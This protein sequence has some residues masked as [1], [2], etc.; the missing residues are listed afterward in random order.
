MTQTN[1]DWALS[2]LG[3]QPLLLW[4]EPWAEEFEVPF[5][6]TIALSFAG[7][8]KDYELGDFDAASDNLVIWASAG[9]TV[10]VYIDGALQD[11]SSAS[12][13]VPGGF[14]GSTREFLNLVFA[15]Q[16]SARLGGRKAQAQRPLSCWGRALR[17]FR[18]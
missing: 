7:E 1:W 5:R 4:L 13:A 3:P 8:S 10:R 18:R 12:L 11:S 14:G 2:N 6:S 17:L 16:P 9:Q 15:D